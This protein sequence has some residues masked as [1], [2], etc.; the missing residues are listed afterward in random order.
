MG[1]AFMSR[2][3][4]SGKNNGVGLKTTASQTAIGKYNAEDPNALF[5][6]GNGTS[7]SD[8]SN[9]FS[10]SEDSTEGGKLYSRTIATVG[11]GS[12]ELRPNPSDVPV[13]FIYIVTE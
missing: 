6:V 10:V 9:A 7:D 13:G 4:S 5:I 3:N 11:W 12:E 1:K 2:N 8:R